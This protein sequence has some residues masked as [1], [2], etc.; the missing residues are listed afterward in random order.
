M[1]RM[2]SNVV[3]I[4]Y[5]KSLIVFLK[6]CI[7]KTKTAPKDPNSS[8]IFIAFLLLSCIIL[9][10]VKY[11]QAYSFE[12]SCCKKSLRSSPLV[13]DSQKHIFLEHE[14]YVLN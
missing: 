8:R 3:I 14:Q 6:F 10:A 12:K 7:L 2:G 13:R 4:T 9:L 5:S 1:K 11:L